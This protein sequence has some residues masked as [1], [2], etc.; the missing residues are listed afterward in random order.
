MSLLTK[1][2]SI[3]L[4][5]TVVCSGTSY[6]QNAKLERA[7]ALIEAERYPQALPILEDVLFDQP[8]NADANYLAAIC[9][10]ELNS[11]R[12]AEQLFSKLRQEPAMSERPLFGYYLALCYLLN[13][14]FEDAENSMTGFDTIR[15]A[16]LYRQIQRAKLA[17]QHPL[18]HFVENLGEGVN[19]KAPE[20]ST[21]VTKKG[22]HDL[23][24]FTRRTYEHQDGSFE[25]TELEL[26]APEQIFYSLRDKGANSWSKAK[27]LLRDR[28]KSY[29]EATVQL[30]E[31]GKMLT[32]HNS[33]L[34]IIESKDGE[35][36]KQH[37][38]GRPFN[39][40]FREVHGFLS[41]DGTKMFIV[42]DRYTNGNNLDILLSEKTPTGSWTEPKPINVVNSNQ[43][44][45]APFFTADGTL[46]F[47]SRGHS[48]L[49]GYDIYKSTYDPTS[50]QFSQPENLGYPINSTADDIFY[51][52]HNGVGY[53]A[54]NRKGGFGQE[55]IYSVH[56]KNE[57]VL[58]GHVVDK[59][60]AKPISGAKV[61][62]VA[63]NGETTTVQ[64]NED[65]Y[66][67]LKTI[68]QNGMIIKVINEKDQLIY[69]SPLELTSQQLA[70]ERIT[71]NWSVDNV[72]SEN[73]GLSESGAYA[74]VFGQ[75]I[76][77]QMNKLMGAKVNLIDL[78]SDDT[79]AS[80]K[81][82][83]EGFYK[84]RFH[85]I[86]DG[87]YTVAV[88]KKA[89]TQREYSFAF[90]GNSVRKDFKLSASFVLQ[91]VPFRYIYY[92]YAES[93]LSESAYATLDKAVKFLQD[94]PN[95]KMIVEGHTDNIGNPEFNKTLSIN[96]A[97]TV[98][99]YLID[100][101]VPAERVE[102]I[103]YGESRPLA[104]NDDEREGRELNRRVMLK[105]TNYE[106]TATANKDE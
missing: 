34:Y 27:Y 2:F 85:P 72:W 83:G 92:D 96:R 81:T 64:A 67:E 36:G 84:L 50:R 55:D 37:S 104:S 47:A 93:Y 42:S 49:G 29:N 75:V 101:G 57:T 13:E 39:S 91:P 53:F 62:V 69:Q 95:A 61:T 18:E 43:D 65:G 48:G 87:T 26:E 15:W 12:R 6:S 4:F 86:E 22:A 11:Y 94:N 89:H 70:S 28:K 14:R 78:N 25:E 100:M 3:L 7:E 19:S 80:D 32:Y 76:N 60:T 98:A 59:T 106:L 99:N 63:A 73:T 68:P 24:Y 30:L 103:G 21:L 46:Y 52:V 102:A 56:Y 97:K 74:Y 20:Y 16:G 88:S 38:L 5:I 44:E 90:D 35:W 10:L 54:S 23:M 8:N 31:P 33:N 41:D 66:Y 9:Y 79:I 105:V 82:D 58:A 17:Y 1:A 71:L 77:E 40:E 45:E 51:S